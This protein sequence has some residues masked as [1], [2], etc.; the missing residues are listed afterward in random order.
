M[1]T[2]M[3]TLWMLMHVDVLPQDHPLAAI[4]DWVALGW[5]TGFHASEWS[6]TTLH[7]FGQILTL[8]TKPPITFIAADFKFF[9][10]DESPIAYA[11]LCLPPHLVVHSEK[12]TEQ[13]EKNSSVMQPTPDSVWLWQPYELSAVHLP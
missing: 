11:I 2:D 6:Q 10:D 12:Y 7:D 9:Q 1:I 4:F 5:Y 8:P 13:Q 3:I